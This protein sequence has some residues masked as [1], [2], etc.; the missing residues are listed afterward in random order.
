VGDA[1]PL[2]GDIVVH[3]HVRA[4]VQLVQALVLGAQDVRRQGL[5]LSCHLSDVQLKL[6]EHGL[7][8]QR[9]LE[10]VEEMVD[11]VRPLLLI[12]GLAQQIFHQQR[13]VAGRGHL[14]H[15]DHVVRIDGVLVLVG[16]VGVQSVT[17]LMGQRELAVQR[18]GVVQ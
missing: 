14:C 11:E 17:H 16:Q 18:S 10:L 13:L 15:E 12:R 9:S 7:T 6:G 8:V 1:R 3:H 5:S 2:H 4:V